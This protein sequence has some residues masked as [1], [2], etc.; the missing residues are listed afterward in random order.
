MREF[1]IPGLL[2][3]EIAAG[4]P[5]MRLML[6]GE[7][8]IAFRTEAG[9]VGVM[10]HRC[11]HR[12]AS[13]FYARTDPDG[14]R[15]VY[16]GWKFDAAGR[17][18]DQPN[19]PADRQMLDVAGAR[20]YRTAERGGV[21]WVYM[22]RRAVPP[23]LPGFAVL[24][25]PQARIS[26]WCE[27]RACN[28]LQAL[29]GEIDTSHAG[30]L[31]MGLSSAESINGPQGNSIDVA[32]RAVEYQVQDTEYGMLAGAHRDAG[33]GETYWRFAQFLLPFWTQPPPS[34]F[35]TEAVARA[36]VPLDDEHT[37]LFAIS[38]DTY[39]MAQGPN[40]R[41]A[42]NPHAGFSLD[43]DFLPNTTDWLGRW[44]L[45]AQVGND[46]LIDR[47]VQRSASYSGIEGLD[48]QDVAMQESMGPIV[49]HGLE[50]LVGSDLAVAR[51]RR[52]LLQAVRAHA[53]SGTAPGC[54]DRPDAYATWSGYLTAPTA[55]G[56]EGAYKAN[57][58][59]GR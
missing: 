52:R 11:P 34:A 20:A 13:L 33:D 29:E 4:A 28:Y 19:V 37:M 48:V 16:H 42:P 59:T 27:Q 6:L 26:A 8:L 14:I 41:R 56:F 58:P 1:W 5:P 49:D 45:A 43:Y 31:H 12:C 50:R 30:F 7:K 53:E 24:D 23:P 17:C 2:S 46:H 38:T 40:A 44:R 35:G 15:C 47:E 9:A 22:G 21:V 25:L 57:L 10:D 32:N 39:M 55:Q 51:M 3:A 18:L 36:W 54:I